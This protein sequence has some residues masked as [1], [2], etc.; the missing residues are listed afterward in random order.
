MRKVWSDFKPYLRWVIIG[1]TLFFLLQALKD[2]ASEVAAI[3]VNGGGWVTL[4]IALL[5]TIIAHTWSGW[6]WGGILNSLNQPVSMGW[7]IPVYLKTNLAKYLPGNVWH[8]YGRIVAVT[9]A[10]GT[11]GAATLSV[12]LEPLLMAAAALLMAVSGS[13]LSTES[14]TLQV[15]CLIVVGVGIHPRIL[16][17]F[18]QL[19][20]RFKGKATDADIVKLKQYPFLPL[21]GEL[22]FLVLRGNGFLLTLMALTPVNFNQIPQLLSAFSTAWVLGLVIPGAPGGIGVFEA[23]A[24]ALLDQQ[25][26]PALLIGVVALF[27][28]ISILA[29][30]IAAGIA[31]LTEQLFLIK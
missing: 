30:A 28:V 29:E 31:T 23:T 22:C 10:G 11:I 6:V 8:F 14:R 16:N 3:R 5:V 25:F 7:V 15:I 9:N 20:S 19:M 24:I 18:I 4:A 1:G 26:S 2:H 13:Q 17:L 12:L 21:L 27:R